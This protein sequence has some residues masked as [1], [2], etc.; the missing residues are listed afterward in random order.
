MAHNFTNSEMFSFM[1]S[2]ADDREKLREF[3]LVDTQSE[4]SIIVNFLRWSRSCEKM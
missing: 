2:A 3:R 1:R 4:N